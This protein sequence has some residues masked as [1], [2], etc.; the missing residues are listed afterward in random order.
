MLTTK[1]QKVH[2]KKAAILFLINWLQPALNSVL[3][4]VA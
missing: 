2:N 1:K 3:G 4:E